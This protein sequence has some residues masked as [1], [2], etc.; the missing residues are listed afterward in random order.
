MI[1]QIKNED[2]I[3]TKQNKKRNADIS[4]FFCK[5]NHS[6]ESFIIEFSNIP[7]QAVAFI[8][9]SL[10]TIFSLLIPSNLYVK[11]IIPSS[12]FII[13][14]IILFSIVHK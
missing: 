3:Q 5:N 2:L 1:F 8:I 6:G 9:L 4:Q 10:Y 13:M 12:S 11:I 7:G 14:L